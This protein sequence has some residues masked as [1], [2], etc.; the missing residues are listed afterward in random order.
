M[1]VA[2]GDHGRALLLRGGTVIDGTAAGRF[3]A[4]VRIEDGSIAAVG[5]SLAIDGATVLDVTGLIVAPGF[6]D[7]HTHDDQIVLAAPQMLPKISQGVTTVVVGNCGI[8]LAPLV[9][10]SV[11]PPLNLLGAGEKY[12]HPTMSSYAAA[13]AAA[14]P[15]VNVAALV[16][17]STLRVAVMD[18]PY[19]PATRGE[20]QRMAEL[21]KEGMDAGATGFSSGVFYATGAAADVDE[22]AL[23]AGIAGDAGGIYTTHIRQEMD[24]VLASLDEAFATARRGHVPVVISHHKCAGPANWGRTVETLA[25]IDSMRGRQPIGLD[26]YPY[27]AGSTVLRNDL[28]DGVIDVLVTW[29][30]PHPEMSARL[31][32]DIAREWSCTQQEA[33]ERLQPGGACYFQ[34][35]ED[36]VQR[37][38]RYPATMIGSDGL[39]HDLH[40]HPRLWG[41]FPRVLGHYSRD[42]G[43]FPLEIAVHKM[44]ALSAR[45]FNLA[46]RGEL[47]TGFRAD[48]TVFDAATIADSATFARPTQVA[49]GIR[50]VLVNGVMSYAGG[51]ATGDRGGRFLR[52]HDA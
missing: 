4:D 14:Q 52:L 10:A 42:L 13:V 21:L 33:C 46:Q 49:Q 12:V 18:D 23:L 6:I 31:L 39:P 51:H 37:V 26:A 28:I 2:S 1:S 38:L 24:E 35:H 43:L 5:P 16:G 48:V 47:R 3:V 34:M 29:S 30:T 15:A 44:T 25:Y 22:L 7:V 45:R 9:R 17:H 8:S 27:V 40:P 20:Q 11:P 50:Y 41:T 19:R 36:D 32:A